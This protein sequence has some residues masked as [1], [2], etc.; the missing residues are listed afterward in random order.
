MISDT[1]FKGTV[2]NRTLPSFALTIISNY[3]VSLC[4][5]N[6]NVYYTVNLDI[7]IR[8][9]LPVQIIQGIIIFFRKN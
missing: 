2:V 7:A 4:L 6:L 8:K 3:A 5:N 9:T 1:D